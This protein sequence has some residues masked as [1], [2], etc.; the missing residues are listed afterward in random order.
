MANAMVNFYTGAKKPTTWD[1]NSFY[2]FTDKVVDG[3]ITYE[4]GLYFGDKLLTNN[5]TLISAVAA[6][7]ELDGR[8]GAIPKG[9]N[10]QAVASNVINYIGLVAQELQ[11]AIDDITE[12]FNEEFV[13]RVDDLET[14]VGT[15]ATVGLRGDVATLKGFV[16]ESDKTGL[17]GDVADLD[18]RLEGVENTLNS[19]TNVMDFIGARTVS[20]S[21]A[22][23]I[24]VTPNAG[25][26]F[27]KGDVVVNND[28]KEYVYDGSAWHEFGYAD[29]N[30]AA[31]DAIQSAFEK[32]GKT[33]T[34][35]KNAENATKLNNVA[36]EN[37]ATKDYVGDTLS[38]TL[39]DYQTKLSD[40]SAAFKEVDY[41]ATK[42]QGV[43]AD[44]A[45]QSVATGSVEGT[46]SVDGNDVAVNGLKDA[47]YATKTSILSSAS[48]TAAE[49]DAELALTLKGTDSYVN[50]TYP[51]T[52]GG[53]KKYAHDIALAAGEKAVLGATSALAQAQK[54]IEALRNEVIAMLT[55]QDIE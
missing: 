1:S 24:T 43:K 15:D 5:S 13:K 9:E 47:A 48:T 28:G 7:E 20:V 38:E 16:G 14:W 52:I 33:V 25:E 49:L 54:D 55:W 51:T 18:S 4:A 21:E 40:K 8:V 30:T 23:I 39:S 37:Y 32:D 22:G 34:N 44:S 27:N 35:A 41:F 29:A 2:L 53:A 6:I 46:I 42:A 50:E 31:I 3:A 12:V 19:V 11:E 36:A 45:V 26:V 17:R 10:G